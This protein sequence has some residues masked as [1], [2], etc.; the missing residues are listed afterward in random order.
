[1]NVLSWGA[2]VLENEQGRTR[3]DRG[4]KLGNLEQTYFLNIL[5]TSL[6]G[7]RIILICRTLNRVIGVL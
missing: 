3:V 5:S 4:S 6:S 7:L 1:M 2:G